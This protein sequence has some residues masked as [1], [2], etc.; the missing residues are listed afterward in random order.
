MRVLVILVLVAL[1]NAGCRTMPFQKT[2]YVPLEN[3]NSAAVRS[4]FASKLPSNFEAINSTVFA[5]RYMKISCMGPALVN[6]QRNRFTVVGMNHV[7]FKL[8]ELKFDNG[9]IDAAYV[10][11]ELEKHE[12]FAKGVCEDIEKVYLDRVPPEDSKVVLEKN[13]VVFHAPKNGGTME[14]V[15]GGKDKLLVEKNFFMAGRKLWSVRY[16]EYIEDQGKVF[17]GGVFLRHYGYKYYLVIRLKE[18]RENE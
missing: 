1:N 3:V 15:F 4:E 18:I 13:R 2:N 5:Y 17:P 12:N 8:F 6:M 10:F 11:P 14:Y 7:G 16:Y 9:A